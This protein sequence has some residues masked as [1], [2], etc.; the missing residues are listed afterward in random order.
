[1]LRQSF[2]VHCRIRAR[3]A[4]TV[5]AVFLCRKSCTIIINGKQRCIRD[6]TWYDCPDGHRVEDFVRIIQEEAE[7]MSNGD[8]RCL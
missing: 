4:L 5:R 7:R 6:G 3:G 2:G 1:M 8:Q